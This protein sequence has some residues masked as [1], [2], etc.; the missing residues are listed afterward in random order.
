MERGEAPL[1]MWQG[2]LGCDARSLEGIVYPKNDIA[3][4]FPSKGE[5]IQT[6]I[7]TPSHE[8][9]CVHSTLIIDEEKVYFHI[10]QESTAPGRQYRRIRDLQQDHNSMC[11]TS[12][13]RTN[14]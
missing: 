2:P 12:A 13:K 9:S 4:S 3:K 8:Q 7:H 14:C 6:T 5:V 10:A 11:L 1:G